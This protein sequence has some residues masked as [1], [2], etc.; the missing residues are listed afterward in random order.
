MTQ[1]SSQMIDELW[2]DFVGAGSSGSTTSNKSPF[3]EVP[4]SD[5]THGRKPSKNQISFEA[6]DDRILTPVRSKTMAKPIV[7]FITK[8]KENLVD[9]SY[10]LRTRDLDMSSQHAL[11]ATEV[12]SIEMARLPGKKENVFD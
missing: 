8:R 6:E 9:R 11:S 3:H 7:S 1:Q 10:F 4:V 5:Q 12:S 2:K